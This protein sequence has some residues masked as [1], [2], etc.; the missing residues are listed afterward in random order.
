MTMPQKIAPDWYAPLAPIYLAIV[1][2]T[3]Q[4][5]LPAGP[6]D[7]VPVYAAFTILMLAIARLE[8][9]FS[10]LVLLAL[11]AWYEA[12]KSIQPDFAFATKG[13]FGLAAF[14]AIST[15]CYYSLASLGRLS[16]AQIGQWLR[17]VLGLLLGGIL[18]DLVILNPMGLV[19]SNYPHYF[20]PI[21]R[22]SGFFAEPSVLGLALPPF[23]FLLI[24][25]PRMYIKYLGK[26]GVAML[27]AII[28]LCPSATL[29]AILALTVLCMLMERLAKGRLIFLAIA[30]P[31]FLLF[32][33]LILALPEFS[34]RLWG[35]L[36]TWSPDCYRSEVESCG[37][38]RG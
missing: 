28:L 21:R 32:A 26:T 38:S 37:V 6:F 33:T 5:R 25:R 20:L 31:V 30:M 17:I 11:L 12:A 3:P 23:I 27:A 8:I 2:L 34:V 1:W 10:F 19:T 13:L 36:V 14:A 22:F 35:A 16:A 9:K 29:F 18:L 4:F 24:F 7:G 15:T